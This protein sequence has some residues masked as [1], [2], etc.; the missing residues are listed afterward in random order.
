MT[1]LTASMM[2]VSEP[3]MLGVLA[4]IHNQLEVAHC[5][6][7]VVEVSVRDLRVREWNVP[8]RDIE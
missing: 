7:L 5:C 6:D 2:A 1:R 8:T 4:F 3:A